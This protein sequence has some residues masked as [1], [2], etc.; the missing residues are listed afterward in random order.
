M[1]QIPECQIRQSKSLNPKPFKD[2][3]SCYVLKPAQRANLEGP[4]ALQVDIWVG[5]R[6]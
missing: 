2:L 5:F 1:P 4:S 3:G 6:V